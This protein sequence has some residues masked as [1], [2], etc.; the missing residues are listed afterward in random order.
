MDVG[1]LLSKKWKRI[2]PLIWVA[3][4]MAFLDRTYISLAQLGMASDLGITATEFGLASGIF[5]IGYFILE[6][7]GTYI[8]ER[9]SAR[10]WIM[11]IMVSW[12][13]VASLTGLIQNALQLYIARFILGLMEASFFPGIIVYLTHWF[14]AEERA[15]AVGFFMSAVA[16]SNAVA[17]PIG[18]LLLGVNWFG[19]AGWR[20]LLI[21]E[22]IPSIIWGIVILFLLDDWPKDARWLTEEEKIY[23]YNQLEAEKKDKPENLIQ[24]IRTGLF[25]PWVILLALVYFLLVTS[26]YGV[27]F[28]SPSILKSLFGSSNVLIGIMNGIL[29]ALAAIAMIL[30]G[31][32]ADRTR[33]RFYHSS[34]PMIVGFLGFL[35]LSLF[36]NSLP[37]SI[38]FVFLIIATVGVYAA[39][40]PFWPIPQTTLYGITR[41]V[42]IG[43][44]NSIGNLGGF[45]GPYI[46]GY[47][48]D[49]TGS[50]IFSEL[51][52]S[53]S[54]VFSAIVLLSLR[55]LMKKSGV[56]FS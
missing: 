9:Y 32:H 20:W 47:L 10:I 41:A 54:V 43:W 29:Y 22:G 5:F 46:F 14:T 3:Y 44:I 26:L 12:G 16:V 27:T 36:T 48:R 1:K 21:L 31:R 8:V 37:S 19:L 39:F 24:S 2:I 38:L 18:G 50:L 56:K 13:I 23:I 15:R 42:A 28:F 6:V 11:R 33:E 35:L 7:P 45:A 4:L 25:H 55:Y 30:N 53:L 49:L 17:S 40:P 34:I 52:L 51:F